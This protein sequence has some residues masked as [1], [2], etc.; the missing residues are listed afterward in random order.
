MHAHPLDGFHD[1]A[2]ESGNSVSGKEVKRDPERAH[3]G[4]DG[5][6]VGAA[7][8]TILGQLA[9]P[10]GQGDEGA[11]AGA[12]APA[13]KTRDAKG[14]RISERRVDSGEAEARY[15]REKIHLRAHPEVPLEVLL[16]V[17]VEEPG[18]EKDIIN[19]LAVIVGVQPYDT[20][21]TDHKGAA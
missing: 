4:I 1:A 10:D 11:S 20:A 15:A 7:V 21:E 19:S 13:C 12:H 9:D 17:N 2:R 5:T 6:V 8:A 14:P 16:A 18:A 3:V